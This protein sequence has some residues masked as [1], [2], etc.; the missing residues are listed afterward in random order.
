VSAAFQARPRNWGKI[1]LAA[2]VLPLVAFGPPLLAERSA[3]QKAERLL[4]DDVAGSF[5]DVPKSIEILASW[6]SAAGP[7]RPLAHTP[8]DALCQRLLLSGE[9]ALVRVARASGRSPNAR[10]SRHDY[11]MERRPVCPEAFGEGVVMLSESKDALASGNCFVPRP[12]GAAPVAARITITEKS[13]RNPANLIEDLAAVSGTIRSVRALEIQAAAAEGWSRRLRRTQVEYSYWAA[14]FHL[15]YAQCYGMCMGR[16][17]FG[18]TQRTLNA[19]DTVEAALQALGLDSVPRPGPLGPTDRVIAMLDHAG[20]SFTRNQE[21]IITD[22]ATAMRGFGPQPVAFTDKDAELTLRLVQDRRLTNFVFVGEL[23]GRY[24]QLLRDN[25]D[26]FLAEM[27]ARGANSEFTN[28]FGA[29]MARLDPADIVPRRERVL[30]LI[31]ANDWK[32]SHG[33]GILSGRLGVD[34][35]ALIAER[36]KRSASAESAALAACLADEPIGRALVPHLLAYLRDRPTSDGFP[37][38]ASRTAVKALARFGEFDAARELFL[39]RFAKLGA[40]SLP[41]QSAAEVVSDV[42]ACFRG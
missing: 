17:V 3:S 41:R 39:T 20:E 32:W 26:L 25:L 21:Q 29:L 8:C 35:T 22:W 31:R 19:F 23:I 4:A 12:A 18:R 6:P 1:G 30:V 42:N 5:S 34:T 15:W 7:N 16:P 13:A 11:V 36:L 40:H 14:P 9:V 28:R 10:V 38:N 27:E 37:D 33:I 2:C 24:R